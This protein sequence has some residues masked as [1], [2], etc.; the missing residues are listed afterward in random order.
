MSKEKDELLREADKAADLCY[1][2]AIEKHDV[3]E[4]FN[5][6]GDVF[7]SLIAVTKEDEKRLAKLEK[8]SGYK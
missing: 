3:D 6:L 2:R 1:E 8:Q 4:L 7:M 5:K